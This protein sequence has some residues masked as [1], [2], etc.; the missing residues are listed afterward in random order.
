MYLQ[1]LRHQRTLSR[2]YP[3]N[4]L[5]FCYICYLILFKSLYL[6]SISGLYLEL[7]FVLLFHP[8]ALQFFLQAE[9]SKLRSHLPFII[10]AL[11]SLNH[12]ALIIVK[13]VF[14]LTMVVFYLSQEWI[15]PLVLQRGAGRRFENLL[16]TVVGGRQK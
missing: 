16:S 13:S 15:Q 12:C 3:A 7:H 8:Q 14:L 6:L 10:L 1:S 5:S 4:L 9:K 11:F 2:M